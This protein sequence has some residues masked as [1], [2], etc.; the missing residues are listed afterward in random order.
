MHIFIK[1]IIIC[2]FIYTPTYSPKGLCGCWEELQSSLGRTWH[3]I[4]AHSI[5]F[6]PCLSHKAVKK[7]SG[8]RFL[9]MACKLGNSIYRTASGSGRNREGIR[10]WKTRPI[11]FQERHGVLAPLNFPSPRDTRNVGMFRRAMHIYG[12]SSLRAGRKPRARLSNPL[13]YY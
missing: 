12:S 7:S 8:I 3:L 2:P 10:G 6:C 9:K 5:A 4:D 11:I 13:T 1:I